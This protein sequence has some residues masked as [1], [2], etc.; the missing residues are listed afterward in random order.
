[1]ATNPLYPLLFEP[2]LRDYVWGGR[3]LETLYGRTLPPGPVAESWE[4]SGHAGAPTRVVNGRYAGRS[5][6]ELV[7]S[8]GEALLGSRGIAVTGGRRFPLLVKLLDAQQDLSVQVHPDDAYAALHDPNE[9]GKAE[10]WYILAARDDASIVYGLKPGIDRPAFEA[11]IRSGTVPETLVRLPVRPGDCFAIPT[12]TVHAIL[13]GIVAAEVQQTSDATYRLYDWD[14]VGR[15]GKPRELH[16]AK[17]L[18][19]IRWDAPARGAVIPRVLEEQ[20]GVRRLG[21]VSSP[22]FELERFDFDAGAAWEGTCDGETFE[23]WGCVA[24]HAGIHAGERVGLPAVRFALLPAGLGA[25][26]VETPA[27]ATL[28]RAYLGTG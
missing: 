20:P 3:N 26:R 18:D 23:I 15:D 12:G 25:F 1:M 9:G 28:L 11:A 19:V 21:L 6:P 8:L 14:R 5:L 22:H 16:I 10:A 27:G 24:G 2:A 4:V 7:A 17:A 13:G